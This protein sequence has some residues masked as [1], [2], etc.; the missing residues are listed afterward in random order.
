MNIDH[1]GKKE[2]TNCIHYAACMINSEYVPT[3]C[4][5][6]DDMSNYLQ[7]AYWD[8]YEDGKNQAKEWISVK[9]KLPD[10]EN[11]V[12]T[13]RGHKNLIQVEL[14]WGDG[15]WSDD[16]CDSIDVTHWMPL[17]EAPKGV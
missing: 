6:Y 2:C 15:D 10:T 5:V 14:Y 9:D 13:C 17:P 12:L 16:T 7:R 11:E 3:P 4:R 8:G 1:K